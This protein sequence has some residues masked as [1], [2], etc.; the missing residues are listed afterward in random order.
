V[1]PLTALRSRFVHP[2]PP[3]AGCVSLTMGGLV[4]LGW[5]IDNPSLKSLAP[6]FVPMMPNAAVAFVLVGVSLLSMSFTSQRQSTRW[7]GIG[8][9]AAATIIGLVTGLEYL[10]GWDLGIDQ[11]LFYEPIETAGPW[12]PGRMGANTAMCFVLLGVALLFKTRRAAHEGPG[13]GAI[14]GAISLAFGAFLGYLYH[15]QYLYGAGP[16]TP[17]ALH[18]AFTMMVV[19]AGILALHPKRGLMA[20]LISDQAG[21]Y[22]LRRLL[23]GVLVIVPVIGW[24]RLY[25]ERQGLYG[26]SLGAAIFVAMATVA[27]FGLLW[28]IACSMNE[29]DQARRRSDRL[30]ASFMSHLPALAWIKD[31]Q[32]RYVYLNDAFIKAFGVRLEDWRNKTDREVLPG[33]IADQFQVHDAE[34]VGTQRA[35]LTMEIAPHKDGLHESVVSK[36]PIV[37]ESGMVALVGGV[38]VDITERNRIERALRESEEQFR[39]VTEHI[40]EVFWLSDTAK[41]AVLYV[42][43][44]YESIWGR[45]RESLYRAPRSWLEAIHPDDRARVLNA[46]LTKQVNGQYDEEYRVVRPDGSIRWIRDR[47]FPVRDESGFVSRIAGIADDVTERKK[48]EEELQ[49]AHD[50][51]ELRVAERTAALQE[52]QQRLEMA[53]HGAGLA[54]W[55][56]DIETGAVSYNER[57]AQIRGYSLHEVAPHISSRMDGIHPEDL[58]LVEQQLKACLAG[59]IV[60][61]EAE[62]RVH[63]CAGEWTWIL[64]R[65]RVIERNEQGKPLRM[66]GV[67]IDIT[68][69][70]RGELELKKAQEFLTSVLEHIPNMVFV[71]EAQDLRFVQFNKAGEDL[72]GYS[73]RH[74]LGK[75]DYDFFPKE[76]ADFFTQKDREV[77]STQRLV[78]IPSEP[79]HTKKRGTR[80]LHTKKIPL[81][82]EVGKPQYLLGISEDITER[83][84]SEQAL[85]ES[86]QRYSSLVSQATDIIYTA[87]LDGRF[88]FVNAA[89]C[90]MMGYREEELL[91][92]HYLEL[93][94]QDFRDTAQRFYQRQ[95][96]E[97]VP[98]TYFEFPAVT[99][100]GREIWFGQRVQLRFK[101]HAVI[102]VE[103]IARD[104][105]ARKIAEQ[106][107]EERAKCAA[108]VAEV[109]LLLNHEE[110][111]DR[112]LQRCTDAAVH[113]L[114]AAFTR[115]WLLKPGDLCANCHKASLCHDR[116]MCLHLH[117]SSGLSTNLNG[118]F[119]RVP[120]GA[121]KIGRIAQGQGPL[122]TNDVL[123]DDRLP[124]KLWMKEHGLTSF[125]GFPLVV[126]G[127]V[128]GVLGLFSTH[129]ISEP[130]RQTL[131]SVCNGLAAFIARKKSSEALQASET[132]TRA[133]VESA[134]DAVV[135][136]DEQGAITG[137]NSQAA[138]IFGY[139]EREVMGKSLSETIVPPRYPQ[140]H[141]SGLRKFLSSGEGAIL[142]RRIELT[143]LHRDGREFPIELSVTAMRIE[144]RTV[145]SAFL[146]DISERKQAETA[147]NDAF[148]RLRELTRQ[149]S[150]AEEVE[151][152]RIARELHDEFGQVL[153]GLK[154]DV[155]W[156]SRKLSRMN[157]SQD[158]A[159]MQSKAAAMLGSVDGLIQSVRAT[160]A[161]LRPG[162]LDDL[163]L[164]AA[165]EWL[166]GSFRDRTGLPCELT[167]DPVIRETAFVSELATTVFRS[168]QEL[169]TNVMR[170]AQASTVSVLLTARDG[171]LTLTI[172]D[173]GRGI[174]P[175]EWEGGRSLG[176]RGLHERVKLMGG[177]VSIIGSPESGT[178][179]SLSLPMKSDL[180]SSAKER[181]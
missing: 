176:L 43:H 56:W 73:R 169:L 136:I 31:V 1:T 71:K 178:E 160:A 139:E 174:Q 138:S 49:K 60:E 36:F 61:Y 134:L 39:Q 92:K 79:I 119:R 98:S 127:Q 30:F 103:A 8:C 83:M 165:I 57:W 54:S 14:L 18:T 24:I 113:H 104:I 120:L 125:A 50:Q 112:Q 115:I 108:F 110:P 163:G 70:K 33:P 13:D 27:L 63:T 111:I 9:A 55:D 93:I 90:S 68:A 175:Q 45:S 21:G 66:A 80:I 164:I 141:A 75:N 20:V 3:L 53:F 29:A 67:E 81:Y 144:D 143:A 97:R 28:W 72:L 99:K 59:Q 156:L 34:V 25:G 2:L 116:S 114:G 124:N 151:R 123:Q 76:E 180:E 162:V 109:S 146:R 38:A 22:M 46:A 12:V 166:V 148:E 131:E 171:Q 35:V 26:S 137:W 167:I 23:P 117:A 11:W 96:V 145:F 147:L 122:F 168:A 142:N 161:A 121:L 69:R 91:G 74:L 62:M 51:L 64:D 105:T 47:A 133:I 44:A 37:D 41:N 158:T 159:A 15:E 65:G 19:G 173:D 132:R 181:A 130:M 157:S 17:M 101:E 40:Q 126:E 94:R 128:F 88:A 107:L 129:A 4:L 179:V 150:Q 152:R 52:S 7:V 155:S 102:G 118:E 170:H 140:A 87:G 89:S 154:F 86:E 84:Q 135:T 42:S 95:I 78:D 16:Y 48:V 5:T 177:T 106:A 172:H 58:P 85:K 77:L 10:L 32:G 6:G 153:T 149:L 100:D 82:D